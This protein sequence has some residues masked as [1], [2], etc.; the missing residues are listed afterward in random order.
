MYPLTCASSQFG[1]IFVSTVAL[2]LLGILVWKPVAPGL[3]FSM[4]SLAR[5]YLPL[6]LRIIQLDGSSDTDQKNRIRS[7]MIQGV[8][9]QQAQSV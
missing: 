8:V 1:E 2:Y 5:M 3:L 6:L 9:F 7:R 4:V